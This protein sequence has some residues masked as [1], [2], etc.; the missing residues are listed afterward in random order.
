MPIKGDISTRPI[1][2][3]QRHYK[4]ERTGCWIWTGK[5]DKDGYGRV[6]WLPHRRAHRWSYA[7]HVAAIPDGL[8]VLHRCDNPACVNPAHLFPG[9]ALINNQDAMHKERTAKGAKHPRFLLTDA[10]RFSISLMR[11][12]YRMTQDAIALALKISQKTVHRSLT[13]KVPE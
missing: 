11:E 7:E 5:K 3:N 9:T 1:L 12:R 13:G 8:M 6:S 10:V 4:C 2:F